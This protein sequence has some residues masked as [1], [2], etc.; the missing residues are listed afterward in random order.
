MRNDEFCNDTATKFF[1]SHK[2]PLRWGNAL[3]GKSQRGVFCAVEIGPGE[4]GPGEIGP[5]EIGP[6]EIGPGEIGPGE[7]APERSAWD[8]TAASTHSLSAP[9]SSEKITDPSNLFLISNS[10]IPS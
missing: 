7:M 5:G 2:R 6:G 9:H 3:S 8:F 1:P 4:I 10:I